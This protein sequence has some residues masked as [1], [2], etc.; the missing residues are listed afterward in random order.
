MLTLGP[1]E[2]AWHLKALTALL[3]DPSLVPSTHIGQLRNAC[4]STSRD[5]PGQRN[6][7]STDLCL[8]VG[9]LYTRPT[10]TYNPKS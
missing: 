9:Y 4:N 7:T 3:E 6:L 8:R 5:L 10:H 1:E 2:I